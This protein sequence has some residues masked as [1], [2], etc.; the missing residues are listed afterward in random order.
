MV[1]VVK[2]EVIDDRVGRGATTREARARYMVRAGNRSGPGWSGSTLAQA[3][4]LA[5]TVSQLS[6]VPTGCACSLP[7]WRSCLEYL[8]GRYDDPRPGSGFLV[9][10]SL[11]LLPLGLGLGV[12]W[13]VLGWL[14]AACS[15][16][17]AVGS[18][19]CVV[20]AVRPRISIRVRRSTVRY[21]T[22]VSCLKL[23]LSLCNFVDK[24]LG[25]EVEGPEEVAFAGELSA[26]KQCHRRNA[27][28]ISPE[29]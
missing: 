21:G 25:R 29:I 4:L 7:G 23:L 12:P 24:K 17:W 5:W 18:G 26:V 28:G 6:P 19:Q 1:V 13:L 27:A 3:C 14:H 22:A 10:G 11:G 9:L 2:E 8:P 15:G 20:D 16:Q